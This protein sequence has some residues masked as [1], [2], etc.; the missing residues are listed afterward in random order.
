MRQSFIHQLKSACLVASVIVLSVHAAT[1]ELVPETTK[2]VFIVPD[3]I[4]LG[5]SWEQIQIGKL[6]EDPSVK[7]FVNDLQQQIQAQLDKTGVRVG[8]SLEELYDVCTGEIAVVFVEPRKGPQRHSVATIADVK[9]KEKEIAEI[10]ERVQKTMDERKATHEVETVNG[11]AL[12]VYTVPVKI[13]GRKT[14]QAV[15]YSTE[16]KV[17]AVDHLDVAKEI[18]SRIQGKGGKTLKDVEGYQKTMQRVV[19]ESDG[20]APHIRWWVEPLA[21]AKLTRD[22]AAIQKRRRWDV[23]EALTNQGFDAVKGLGGHLNLDSSAGS[24]VKYD[25]VWRVYCYAPPVKGAGRQRFKDA[26]RVLAFPGKDSL[27]PQDWVTSET[28]SYGS[29][30]WEIGEAYEYIGSLV[31]EITGEPGFFE[32]L[33]KGLIEDPNGPMINL[34]EDIVAHL[35]TRATIVTDC[36][37]PITTESERFFVAIA[38]KNKN[39]SPLFEKT[40]EK[41]FKGDENASMLEIDD[42][43][44]WEIRSEEFD[45]PDVEVEGGNFSG[46]ETED[47]LLDEDDGPGLMGNAAFAV[48][49]DHLVVSSHVELIVEVLRRKKADNP[50][51]DRD[52]YKAVESV[53]R[54]LGA[55]D[56]DTL[57]LFSRTDEEFKA[58]YEFIKRGEMP[59]SKGLFGRMLNQLL[60]SDDQKGPR[61]Q[62]IDGKNMPDYAKVRKYLGPIGAYLLAEEEGFY[63]AGVGMS[64]FDVQETLGSA[65]EDSDSD[66]D[67]DADA[68]LTDTQTDAEADLV[69]ADSDS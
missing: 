45:A 61:K 3:A 59:Q 11:V 12:D 36:Q 60:S 5:S 28:S 13:G 69:N 58:T 63:G 26:A 34:D 21:Y 23:L 15:F 43:K 22:A 16:D 44:I 54:Q 10:R 37:M 48:V 64:Q 49:K 19:E 35:G 4:V 51:A 1:D 41:I 29:A 18:L 62:Q 30:T 24:D 67:A 42:H 53:L 2:G 33:K 6:G 65:A 40:L 17:V 25:L 46:F 20:L 52:E 7:P 32:D 55:G 9:G 57:R 39:A 31:D 38:L 68:D 50:L 47:D 14:F 27:Q 8:V 56:E 66:A